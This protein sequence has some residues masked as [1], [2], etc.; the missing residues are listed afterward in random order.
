MKNHSD[1]ADIRAI[2]YMDKQKCKFI[3][4][5]PS[6][7]HVHREWKLYDHYKSSTKYTGLLVIA[8]SKSISWLTILS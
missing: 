4:L 1:F 7:N 8:Q 6:L 5:A 2:A 3:A